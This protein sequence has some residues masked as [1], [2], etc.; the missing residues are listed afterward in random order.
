MDYKAYKA[1]LEKKILQNDLAIEV[2][3]KDLYC[4]ADEEIV[5]LLE[6]LLRKKQLLEKELNDLELQDV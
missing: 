6:S 1:Q 3:K 5:D 4:I 2:C